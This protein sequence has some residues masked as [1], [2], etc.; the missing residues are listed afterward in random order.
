MSPA[1][2][3]LW[4]RR[5]RA[6]PLKLIMRR[7]CGGHPHRQPMRRQLRSPEHRTGR[8]SRRTRSY[9]LPSGAVLQKLF[10]LTSVSMVSCPWRGPKWS[11]HS[12]EGGWRAAGCLP[13]NMTTR[14]RSLIRAGFL[15]NCWCR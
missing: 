10:C 1:V 6:R 4:C 14:T 2:V 9:R 13:T 8:V 11:M 7:P 15:P 5:Y 3:R 12:L